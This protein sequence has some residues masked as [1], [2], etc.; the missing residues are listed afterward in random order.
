MICESYAL[1]QVFMYD[2]HVKSKENI[3]VYISGRYS[4][5]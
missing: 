4:F 2:I 5:K 1:K 3:S